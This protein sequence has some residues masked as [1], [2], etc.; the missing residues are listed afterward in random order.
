M[1]Q[2]ETFFD[3]FGDLD[4]LFAE[5]EG[6]EP[7][8]RT[9]PPHLP[10][11]PHE[12]GMAAAL[13]YQDRENDTRIARRL[14]ISRRTLVRWKRRPEFVAAV[15]APSEFHRQELLWLFPVGLPSRTR[16]RGT[17]RLA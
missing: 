4:D 3:L 17:V 14:G 7:Y 6:D 5:E 13:C 10:P 2:N 16:R 8:R 11:T 9:T 12:V 1:Q 15:A